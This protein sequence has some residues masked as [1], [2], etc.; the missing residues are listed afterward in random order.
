[1][2]YFML[3]ETKP[4]LFSP[5]QYVQKH[6]LVNFKIISLKKKI[7][8]IKPIA[9]NDYLTLGEK[10]L[11]FWLLTLVLAINSRLSIVHEESAKYEELANIFEHS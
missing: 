5:H 9:N 2:H 10:K 8:T 3:E 4:K 1:M 7:H 6:K 11:L